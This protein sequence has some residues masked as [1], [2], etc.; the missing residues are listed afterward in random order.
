[1]FERIA[2]YLIASW[3]TVALAAPPA[4]LPPRRCPS[5]PCTLPAPPS[6]AWSPRLVPAPGPRAL[7]PPQSREKCRGNAGAF[8]RRRSYGFYTA[9]EKCRANAGQN[10]GQNAGAPAPPRGAL[11]KT[12]FFGVWKKCRGNAGEMPG[13]CRGN[14]GA[15]GDR[16]RPCLSS[17]GRLLPV[18]PSTSACGY[19]AKFSACSALLCTTIPFC[20]PVYRR[21]HPSC[22]AETAPVGPLEGDC[23]L[24]HRRHLPAD[25]QPSSA[26]A[27]CAL[28]NRSV[29]SVRIP[30]AASVVCSRDRTVGPLEGLSDCQ[31]A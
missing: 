1:M 5:P 26:G 30:T 28:H 7:P 9:R 27:C 24:S 16:P 13:K 19:A 11:R 20:R 17:G 12:H 31:T 2:S 14:A 22:A 25:T 21:L 3:W 4:P 23:S 15:G 18:A 29:L 10:A 8:C 6:R